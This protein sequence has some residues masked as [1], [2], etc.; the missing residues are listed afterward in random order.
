VGD[1]TAGAVPEPAGDDA[2]RLTRRPPA[3]DDR[4]RITRRPAP[5]Q[6]VPSRDA[7]DSATDDPDDST[8]LGSRGG[9]ATEDAGDAERTRLGGRRGR[10]DVPA[11]G[12]AL[13]PRSRRSARTRAAKAKAQASLS[14]AQVAP[15]PATT[16][17]RPAKERYAIRTRQVEA[18]P[19]V[20]DTADPA[21]TT[22]DGGLAARIAR[23]RTLRTRLTV[24]V[25]AA[26]ALTVGS[27]VGLV[28]LIAG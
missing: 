14:P 13:S 15:E 1:A 20:A 18:A 23:R 4:T 22:G 27:L 5:E 7:T 16:D 12:T 8:R 6:P 3:P 24:L 10:S 17:E 25:S 26:A 9:A 21:S 2:T 11:D 19:P 28:L